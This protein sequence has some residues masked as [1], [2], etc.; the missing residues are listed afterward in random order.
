MRQQRILL[1]RLPECCGS[2]GALVCSCHLRVPVLSPRPTARFAS[3]TARPTILQSQKMA[4]PFNKRGIVKKPM[5]HPD[6]CASWT[7]AELVQLRFQP[8]DRWIPPQSEDAKNAKNAIFY[9]TVF[10]TNSRERYEWF[11]RRYP[12]FPCELLD[13]TSRVCNTSTHDLRWVFADPIYRR[14]LSCLV[15]RITRALGPT[16]RKRNPVA[17]ITAWKRN[18]VAKPTVKKSCCRD[19]QLRSTA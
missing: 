9:R 8:R 18:A 10:A 15:C 1:C 16:S 14:R 11:K 5:N 6:A 17:R 19:L 4:R 3:S 2:R 12:G 7:R 13:S